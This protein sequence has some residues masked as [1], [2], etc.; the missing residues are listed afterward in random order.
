MR[1]SPILASDE[2]NTRKT[3]VLMIR[4]SYGM[5]SNRCGILNNPGGTGR[6]FGMG[7][8]GDFA[9]SVS[10]THFYVAEFVCTKFLPFTSRR[11]RC[12]LTR[13]L[14]VTVTRDCS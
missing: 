10:F 3:R 7:A 2:P 1:P 4:I 11:Q 8:R 5:V 13:R 9:I 14:K 12:G 6:S